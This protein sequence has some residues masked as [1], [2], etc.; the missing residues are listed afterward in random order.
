MDKIFRKSWTSALLLTLMV[1]MP[2]MVLA[3]DLKDYSDPYNIFSW[4]S[5]GQG[6]I[7]I[8]T[9]QDQRDSNGN[10]AASF[11]HGSIVLQDTSNHE[12]SRLSSARNIQKTEPRI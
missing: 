10:T 3:Q 11:H 2:S 12:L 6:V 9:M 5:S 4:Y 7:H 1:M 8:T